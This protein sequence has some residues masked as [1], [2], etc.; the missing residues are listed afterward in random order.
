MSKKNLERIAHDAQALTE[1]ITEA[2]T[3]LQDHLAEM[4]DA[5]VH[6]DV[7]IEE[8]SRESDRVQTRI[9]R[10]LRRAP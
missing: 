7:I 9:E 4:A 5:A 10:L 3:G 1:R 8:L 2:M 6:I